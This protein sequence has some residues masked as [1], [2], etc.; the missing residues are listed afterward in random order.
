MADARAGAMLG[1]QIWRVRHALHA[2][3]NHDIGGS[4][5]KRVRRHDRSLHARATH[6]VDRRRLYR[7]GQTSL[8]RRLPGGRSEERRVGEECVSTCRSRWSPYHLKKKKVERNSTKVK[9]KM[10]NM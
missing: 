7:P 6:L 1:K 9:S 10:T 2:A 8:E 4:G 3:R 5:G